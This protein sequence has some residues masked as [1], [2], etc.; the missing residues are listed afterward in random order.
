LRGIRSGHPPPRVFG[1]IIVNYLLTPYY[2][3]GRASGIPKN[4]ISYK[5]H[6]KKQL[7]LLFFK[8]MSEVKKILN[9]N[10]EEHIIFPDKLYFSSFLVISPQS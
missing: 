8:N 6:Y 9:E 7:K 1:G 4:L 10:L 3:R 5:N 2:T